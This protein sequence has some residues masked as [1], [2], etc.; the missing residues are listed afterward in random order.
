MRRGL[1]V[2]GAAGGGSAGSW[3]RGGCCGRA[4]VAGAGAWRG[5]LL[6]RGVLR[7]SL[8][9]RVLP[10]W[11]G[12]AGPGRRGGVLCWLA[13]RGGCDAC[14]WAAWTGHASPAVRALQPRPIDDTNPRCGAAGVAWVRALRWSS[15]LLDRWGRWPAGSVF[16]A[17]SLPD[18]LSR[19]RNCYPCSYSSLR[20]RSAHVLGF[21]TRAGCRRHSAGADPLGLVGGLYGDHGGWGR[22]LWSPPLTARS[23]GSIVP[24]GLWISSCSRACPRR[25]DGCRA[26]ALWEGARPELVR[27]HL[28]FGPWDVRL[29]WVHVAGVLRLN[30][31][32]YLHIAN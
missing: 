5:R 18:D 10:V 15:P 9:Q 22:L 27:Y 4:C 32:A 6:R 3:R 14:G 26:R 29:A 30:S 25:Q 23:E 20:S 21:Q 11:A 1:A 24:S 8:A 13:L 31:A 19:N 28:F 17:L 12:R 7:A 2:A 16:G